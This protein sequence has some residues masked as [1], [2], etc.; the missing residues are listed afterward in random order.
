MPEL[1]ITAVMLYNMGSQVQRLTANFQSLIIRYFS[2][3]DTS[4]CEMKKHQVTRFQISN[5]L[6]NKNKL[7]KCFGLFLTPTATQMA[8]TGIINDHGHSPQPT[9]CMSPTSSLTTA[10]GSNQTQGKV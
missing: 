6:N 1:Y 5:F 9:V 10:K 7:Y 4:H 2:L 8:F 3:F